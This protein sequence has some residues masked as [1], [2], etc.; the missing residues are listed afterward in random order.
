M[1]NEKELRITNFPD[2]VKRELRA[3]AQNTGVDLGQFIKIKL[4]DVADSYPKE[5]K[6]IKRS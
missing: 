5:D 2:K 4:K 6:E 3:I 1:A